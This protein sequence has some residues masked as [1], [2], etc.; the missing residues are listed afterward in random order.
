MI[1]LVYQPTPKGAVMDCEI[2]GQP[3]GAETFTVIFPGD[4]SGSVLTGQMTCT[5]CCDECAA[6]AEDEELEWYSNA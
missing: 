1:D 6:S 4:D 3:V 5:R 2:C